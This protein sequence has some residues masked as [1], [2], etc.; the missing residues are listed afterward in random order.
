MPV[1]A[2]A[3]AFL[4]ALL[5]SLPAGAGE[6]RHFRCNQSLVG[7]GEGT[8]VVGQRCGTPTSKDRRIEQR[9]GGEIITV[10]E[11][12]YDRGPTEFVRILRFENG[13]LAHIEVGDYGS[14]EG[15]KTTG[16]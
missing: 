5:I 10:D 12:V 3:Y 6:E 9:F 2:L 11:W 15:A 7:L 1:R 13:R 14:V 4:G 16:R 8:T